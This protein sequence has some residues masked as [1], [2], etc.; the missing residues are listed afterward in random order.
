[1]KE[2]INIQHAAAPGFIHR[3]LSILYDSLLVFGLLLL[4]SILVTLPLGLFTGMETTQTLP[5][6]PLFKIW[7]AAI[8]PAFFILFWL[9]GGQTLGMRTWRLMVIRNDGYP[10]HAKDAIIRFLAAMLS[11]GLL[12]IGFFWALIDH[13]GLTWHDRISK[14]RLIQLEKKT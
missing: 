5:Q 3:C 2:P 1:M 8:P 10:L 13:Q 12:G 11:W 14:T 6:H 4:G 7:L 9:K